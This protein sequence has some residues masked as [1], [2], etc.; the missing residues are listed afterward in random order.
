LQVYIVLFDLC[1]NILILCRP[2]R[3]P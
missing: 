1:I 3:I 2:V